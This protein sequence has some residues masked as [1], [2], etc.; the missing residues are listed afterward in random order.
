MQ[1]LYPL[2][3]EK[4]LKK[5]R[6][7]LGTDYSPLSICFPINIGVCSY[8]EKFAPLVLSMKR[9]SHPN[10]MGSKT[11]HGRTSFTK[12]YHSINASKSF[13]NKGMEPIFATKGQ[14]YKV[15]EHH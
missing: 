11:E 6:K 14:H 8:I 5:Q 2:Q 15:N 7:G 10:E 3:K 4:K 13:H 9:S 1:D 12:Y